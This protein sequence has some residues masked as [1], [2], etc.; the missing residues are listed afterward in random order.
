M[1]FNDLLGEV[2]TL[3]KDGMTDEEIAGLK[4]KKVI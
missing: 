2:R 3:L 1:L 4:E